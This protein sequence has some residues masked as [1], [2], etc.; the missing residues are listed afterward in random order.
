M[1]VTDCDDSSPSD[2]VDVRWCP[3]WWCSVWV[4]ACTVLLSWWSLGR[5]ILSCPII[6]KS[7]KE[8]LFIFTLKFFCVESELE[9]FTFCISKGLHLFDLKCQHL[10]VLS[11]WLFLSNSNGMSFFESRPKCSQN[12]SRQHSELRHDDQILTGSRAFLPDMKKYPSGIE[13]K[14]IYQATQKLQWPW[15]LTFFLW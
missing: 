1:T 10:I 9:P 12:K 8:F 14:A 7:S 11:F 2:S 13:E 6:W 5:Q 3:G 15:R 4:C